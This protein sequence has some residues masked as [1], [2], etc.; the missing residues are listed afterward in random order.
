MDGQTGDRACVVWLSGE[1]GIME[2]GGA[3]V[4]VGVDE[5][6]RLLMGV[7]VPCLSAFEMVRRGGSRVRRSWAMLGS[8]KRSKDEPYGRLV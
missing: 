5:I 1:G 4:W 6:R 2:S 3:S 8:L 7:A